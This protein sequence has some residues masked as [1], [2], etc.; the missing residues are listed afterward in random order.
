MGW[1]ARAARTP[2]CARSLPPRCADAHAAHALEYVGPQCRN[3]GLFLGFSANQSTRITL[4]EQGGLW[5]CRVRQRRALWC[6]R[7]ST[8]T[9]LLR[10][11][12]W[13]LGGGGATTQAGAARPSAP[14]RRSALLSPGPQRHVL[15]NF[16]KWKFTA[17][18]LFLLF[19][20]T[21]SQNAMCG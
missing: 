3:K 2:P 17:Q 10:H 8:R 12:A 16:D 4:S 9:V 7:S 11:A 5:T 21:G 1:A 19:M 20:D 14:A 13:P 15:Y 18:L 6:W